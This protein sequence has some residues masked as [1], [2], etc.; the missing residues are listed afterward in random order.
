MYVRRG[1]RALLSHLLW[2]NGGVRGREE[3]TGPSYH[4][5]F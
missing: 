1:M 4:A 3:S 5:S 2:I